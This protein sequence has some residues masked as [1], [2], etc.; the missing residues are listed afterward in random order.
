MAMA[1][2]TNVGAVGGD[3][4]AKRRTVTKA[5]NR[6][7]SARLGG[8][9][10]LADCIT[11][12]SALSLRQGQVADYQNRSWIF[13]HANFSLSCWQLIRNP[14][15]R[16][17]PGHSFSDLIEASL[18]Q[19]ILTRAASVKRTAR[20]RRKPLT[21]LKA[22]RHGQPDSLIGLLIANAAKDRLN[23]S[24]SGGRGTPCVCS[25]RW[26]TQSASSLGRL[27]QR[28]VLRRGFAVRTS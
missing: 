7:G 27:P 8:N 3:I 15:Q 2:A 22:T 4:M 23:S 11:N 10:F 6:V 20:P 25:T 16:L 24:I 5:L 28:K 1:I 9:R 13:P 17:C 12:T 14:S 19:L 18:R 21:P 26:P